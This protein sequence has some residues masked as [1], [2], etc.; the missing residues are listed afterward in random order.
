MRIEPPQFNEYDLRQRLLA[1]APEDGSVKNDI[2]IINVVRDGRDVVLSDGNYVKPQRWIES[3]QQR[4]KY[5][6]ISKSWVAF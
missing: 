5:S 3:M 2:A 6:D 1:W 4:E